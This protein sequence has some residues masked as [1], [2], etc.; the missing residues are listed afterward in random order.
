MSVH[1]FDG[2]LFT[3]VSVLAAN[4]PAVTVGVCPTSPGGA[5]PTRQHPHDAGY[6]LSTRETVVVDPGCRVLAPTGLRLAIPPGFAGFVM[7]RSGLAARSG[8]TVLNAP[9]VIDSGFTGEVMVS[10]LNTDTHS[11]VTL[12]PGDRI[13]QLVVMPVP[14][15]VFVQQD[16]MAHTVRGDAGFGS[17]GG[18]GVRSA[19][20]EQE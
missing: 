14:A 15:V 2:V 16:D 17:T 11:R 3:A 8:I 1:G 13:A 9:G 7:P 10:L 5:L 18:G 4:T 20:E 19:K 6:D 12:Q